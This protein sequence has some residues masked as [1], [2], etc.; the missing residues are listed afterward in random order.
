MPNSACQHG[1]GGS[2]G[3]GSQKGG[4]AI[5]P[6][7][8]KERGGRVI[9]V[10]FW[11]T[12]FCMRINWQNSNDWPYSLLFKYWVWV[13]Y[14]M[15]WH[16]CV[17]VDVL[18]LVIVGVWSAVE[19]FPGNLSLS[20][21]TALPWASVFVFGSSF[22]PQ[23]PSPHPTYKS[24]VCGWLFFSASSFCFSAAAFLAL[25]TLVC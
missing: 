15:V 4:Q 13:W 23:N 18:L 11:A 21:E 3:A 7:G 19:W 14:S 25:F 10:L 17:F 8:W 12:A 6:S 5:R 22:V 9:F 20:H 16:G 24:I 2:K 1:R